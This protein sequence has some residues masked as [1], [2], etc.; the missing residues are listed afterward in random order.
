MKHSAT[1]WRQATAAAAAAAPPEDRPSPCRR[2]QQADRPLLTCSV[3]VAAASGREASSRCSASS[4]VA[5]R[6]FCR[7]R[8]RAAAAAAASSSRQQQRSAA[9]GVAGMLELTTVRGQSGE[10]PSWEAVVGAGTPSSG[11]GAGYTTSGRV[12]EQAKMEQNNGAWARGRGLNP[13]AESRGAAS[14]AAAPP[15]PNQP[16]LS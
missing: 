4:G 5:G 1:D 7:C 6:A 15:Y 2:R 8:G 13:L 9:L 14:L 10:C 11:R 16:P 3:S 12:D